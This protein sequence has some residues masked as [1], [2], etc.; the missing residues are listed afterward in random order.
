MHNVLRIARKELGAFFASPAAFIFMAAFLAIS[1]FLFFWVDRFFARD[2]ADVRPLFE[3]MPVL[4]IFFVSAVTMRMWSEERRAGTLEFLLTSPVAPLQLVLGKYLACLALVAIALALT[5][6]LPIT[7]SLIGPLD[8]GPVLGGYLAALALASAYISIGLF[9]S[10]R[11]DNQVISLI[12]SVLICGVF[13]LLGSSTLTSLTGNEGGE[14]LRLLGAGSRFESIAR[15]VIDLRDLYYYLSIFGVFLVLN[16]YVLESLRWSAQGREPQHRRWRIVA[17]LTVANLVA[18]NLWLGQLTAARAD[19]TAGHIYSISDETRG[20]L[21]QLQ[22]PLLIRGYFSA[23]THPLL[24][25]LVPRLRDLLKEYEIAGR[26]KVRV[27]FVDPQ[28]NQALEAEANK[29]YG[30]Q[31]VPFQTSSKYQASVTNSYFNILVKYG[32]EYTTLGFRDLIEVKDRGEGEGDLNVDLR[33]PEY[34]ITR[35]IKKVLNSYRGSGDVL[36][37]IPQPVTLE[38]Y[39]SKDKLPDPLPALKTGLEELIKDYQAKAPGKL[40]AEIIDPDADGGQTAKMLQDTYGLEPLAAGLLNPKRFWFD[41]I[42]KSGDKAEQIQLPESL[43]KDG[44]KRNIDAELKRFTPGALRTVALYTPPPAMP[45]LGMAGGSG[46]SFELLQ[47]KLQEDELVDAA[48]LKDGRVPDRADILFVASPEQLDQKQVFAVDQFLMKGG[49]VIVA[50][51]PYQPSLH[52]DLKVTKTPSGLEDW[53]KFQGLQVEDK[54]VL[55]KQSAPFPIP[56]ERDIGDGLKVRQIQLMDY[57]FFADIRSDGL[58][59]GAAPSAGIQQLTLSWASPLTIAPDKAGKRKV[60][61]LIESSPQSW[62]AN[63]T[64]VVPDFREHPATGFPEPEKE[65]RQLL[66]AMVEGE[67]TSFFAGKPSPLAKDAPEQK[68]GKDDA[69]QATKPAAAPKDGPK[70]DKPSITGVIGRSPESARLILIGSGT[71]LSDDVLQLASSVDRTQYLAPVDFAQN[72]VDWSLEDRGL[73]TLRSRGGQFSRTLAPMK[74]SGQMFWEYLNYALALA[75]L[76]IVYILHRSLRLGARRRYL[77]MLG[78][79][80]ATT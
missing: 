59:Q 65:G 28:Q 63:T 39:I 8:W 54:M 17:A 67:F 19:L 50:T 37:S 58:A 24:A 64:D 74:S 45:Q 49:T 66:G 16:L 2:I 76:G 51:S 12:V 80:G 75:G 57:P 9:V 25:P 1:L 5:L 34:T 41:L 29:H 27:E 23:Q 46:P 32:D 10:A 48:D 6:P 69:A 60:V 53:L 7:V 79:E 38:A 72:L 77:N 40:K 71:F 43:D 47:Q 4:M 62:S 44:L 61:R 78:I 20:Y 15:G 11:T 21:R 18:G 26:G 56:T 30:I 33:N 13:Y 42:L 31:P 55:D 14:L 73:L 22:E 36:A 35:A 70:N 52:G 3:W 68:P